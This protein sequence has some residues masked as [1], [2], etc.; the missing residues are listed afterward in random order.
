MMEKVLELS[1]EMILEGYYQGVYFYS[2]GLSCRYCAFYTNMSMLIYKYHKGEYTKPVEV[3]IGYR[4]FKGAPYHV[5][6]NNMLFIFC[7]YG[8]CEEILLQFSGC[9]TM[10]DCKFTPYDEWNLK[11]CFP[12]Q[13]VNLNDLKMYRAMG[14]ESFSELLDELY[15]FSIRI[16]NVLLALEQCNIEDS[17]DNDKKVLRKC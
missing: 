5:E 15:Y 11:N 16:E 3:G 12:C 17:K 9:K 4:R 10:K 6:T 8:V 13:D 2:D 14:E 7:Y 1:D